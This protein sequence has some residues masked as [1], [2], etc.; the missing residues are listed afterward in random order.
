PGLNPY[1]Y[2]A[3]TPIMLVDPT[4]EVVKFIGSENRLKRVIAVF[5][6]EQTKQ[7]VFS[8]DKNNCLQLTLN[9]DLSRDP[10]NTKLLALKSAIDSEKTTTINVDDGSDVII[11]DAAKATIDIKDIEAVG[12][13][14]EI[15]SNDLL[16]HETIEQFHIQV[17]GLDVIDAHKKAAN[18][19]GKDRGMNIGAERWMEDNPD[20]SGKMD[21]HFEV[22]GLNYR[23]GT[24]RI[25]YDSKGNITSVKLVE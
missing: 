6:Q 2:C 8:M 23:T 3:A 12:N 7:G 19:E 21:V 18:V 10:K 16:V 4:G 1:L 15:T 24:I 20:K 11:G 25:E 17:D 14:N 5:Q 9:N 22:S 13:D